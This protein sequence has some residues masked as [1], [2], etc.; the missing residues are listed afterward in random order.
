MRL[1]DADAVTRAL[2]NTLAE[3]NPKPAPAEVILIN[4]AKSIIS[5]V[6]T[7]DPFI[8]SSWRREENE[9]GYYWVCSHCG[10]FSYNG[11]SR[12]CPHCGAKMDEEKAWIKQV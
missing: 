12:Y 5:D 8:H 2:D 3:D 6:P 10:I 1:I 4:F 11:K 9:F 7:I